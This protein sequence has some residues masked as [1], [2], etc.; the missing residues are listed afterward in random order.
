MRILQIDQRG[1]EAIQRLKTYAE[2]HK[3]DLESIKRMASGTQSPV[4]ND[5]NYSCYLHD[6]YRIVF[7]IEQ[8]SSGWYRHISISVDDPQKV[9][10]VPST[11]MIMN[12]FG[13]K[14]TV[15]D[16]DSLWIEPDVPVINV[17]KVSAINLVQRIEE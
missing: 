8:Q 12:E 15:N 17:G 14:G 9:P 3:V 1:K 10:S 6:G 7:S 5:T 16:C 2:G 11:E 4:G 13:F